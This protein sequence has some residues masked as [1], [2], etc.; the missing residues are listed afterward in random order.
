MKDLITKINRLQDQLN[1]EM[2]VQYETTMDNE[3][4]A[5]QVLLLELVRAGAT[6]TKELATTLQVTT[7]AVSQLLNKLEDKGYIYR[8]INPENRREIKLELAEKGQQ[9]FKKLQ[10]FEQDTTYAIYGQ[11]PIE[12]LQ[13]LGRILENL[14]TIVRRD[15]A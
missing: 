5:K 10:Q 14:L 8:A 9:Y 15:K 13:H 12:D 7:S 11:L 4:T 3:L 2:A 6:T 1:I